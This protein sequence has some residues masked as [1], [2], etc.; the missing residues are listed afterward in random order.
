MSNE[1]YKA[2]QVLI[3]LAI[4]THVL[5]Y[6][7]TFAVGLRLNYH[8][9]LPFTGWLVMT[10]VFASVYCRWRHMPGLRNVVEP[11][12]IGTLLSVAI[13]I[14]TYLAM[15]PSL[16]L[17][18][19][20]LGDLDTALGFDWHAFVMFVDARPGLATFLN[21]AYQS[22][23]V[24][25]FVLPALLGGIGQAKRAY[26]MI[27]SY[28]LI[29][30]IAGVV[31][32]LFPA[33]GA[34]PHNEVQHQDLQNINIFYGYFFLEQFH[35][36][37]DDL[38]FVF[39]INNAA[40]IITFPSVHAAVAALCVWAA[41]HLRFFRYPIVLLNLGMATSAVSHGSHY[42]VDVLVGIPLAFLCIALASWLSRFVPAPGQQARQIQVPGQVTA[43]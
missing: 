22:F 15:L 20:Q 31:A 26:Q 12:L 24:Q 28:T 3:W 11:A 10:L 6:G 38:N 1:L 35:G 43:T 36:V 4:A 41:W 7:L 14:S 5:I 42:L 32:I 25:L 27:T 19:K 40:G 30:L 17:A 9:L 21:V 37:R 23:T 39:D 34:F 33:I 13:V 8:T 29:G 2:R 18:D 16:P